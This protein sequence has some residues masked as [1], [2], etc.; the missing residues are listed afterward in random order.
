MTRAF[1]YCEDRNFVRFDLKI[2]GNAIGERWNGE[3][4]VG[5]VS[6]FQ[7]TGEKLEFGSEAFAHGL[8]KGDLNLRS[9]A[10]LR[11]DAG[12]QVLR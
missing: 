7:A 11:A 8:V 9:A 6:R 4:M 3:L 10:R 12:L 5:R 2:F 1:G